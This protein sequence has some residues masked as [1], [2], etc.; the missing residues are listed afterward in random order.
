VSLRNS[1]DVVKVRRGQDIKVF[2]RPAALHERPPASRGRAGQMLLFGLPCSHLRTDGDASHG[3][4]R[5][6]RQH[7]RGHNEGEGIRKGEW[8]RMTSPP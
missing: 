3:P 8:A 2:A 5:R 6:R 1:M 4:N 7:L